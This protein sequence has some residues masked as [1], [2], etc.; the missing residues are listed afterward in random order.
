VNDIERRQRRLDRA[1]FAV[2][3][4]IS[5]GIAVALLTWFYFVASPAFF[6][7][8][9]RPLL[10]ELIPWVALG[11]PVIGLAWMVRLMR[12]PV[13]EGAERWRFRI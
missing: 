7:P 5:I 8:M 12:P 4:E 1:R 9:F 6:K 3:A 13:D 10:F 11:G 2:Y